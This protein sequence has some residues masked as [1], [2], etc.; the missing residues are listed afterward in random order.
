[1]GKGLGLFDF[2]ARL[3]RLN[4]LGDQLEAFS[5][6]ADFKMFHAGL[7]AALGA[8]RRAAVGLSIR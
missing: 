1:M 6:A 4:D 3:Q 7:A 8:G 2:N 5:K